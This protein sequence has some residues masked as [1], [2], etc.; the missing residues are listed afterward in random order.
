MP[1]TGS[2]KRIHRKPRLSF[3]LN[4]RLSGSGGQGIISAGMLLGEAIA[5][6]DGKNV[7][8]SQSY[9]PEA[10]GGAT[11][12]DIIVSSE[13]IFFP[14]CSS[15]DILAALTPEAYEKYAPAVIP[16]GLILV[17]ESAIDV[18]V[19]SASTVRAPFLEQASKTLRNPLAA[20][21]IALGFFAAYTEIVTRQSLRNVV[22]AQ[23]S[24]TKYKE[25]NL[26]ALEAGFRMGAHAEQ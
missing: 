18:L 1:R 10:R 26:K 14:E 12:A 24:G 13:E 4:I 11:R 9:G 21:M 25:A 2:K 7:A 23:F 17:E 8:Q 22:A 19:G 20:N 5:I 16:E 6:G 3:P 15:L